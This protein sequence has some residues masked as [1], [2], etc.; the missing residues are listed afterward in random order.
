MTRPTRQFC[1]PCLIQGSYLRYSYLF[2]YFCL[3]A[4]LDH[5]GVLNC[6]EFLTIVVHLKKI[7]NEEQLSKVF[8][9]FDKNHNGFIEF[10]ELKECLFDGQLDQHN[11]KMVHEIIIDA[12]LDKVRLQ[13]SKEQINLEITKIH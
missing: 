13:N 10:E 12:D 3:K 9:H 11:E 5:N 7:S 4:D 8:H 6:E 2:I 1:D